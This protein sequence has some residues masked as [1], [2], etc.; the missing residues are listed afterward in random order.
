MYSLVTAELSKVKSYM[1]PC[2]DPLGRPIAMDRTITVRLPKELGQAFEALSARLK[3]LPKSV[4]VRVLLSGP[5]SRPL[6]EQVDLVLD[7]IRDGQKFG[8]RK[9]R[10]P[11]NS[12]KRIGTRGM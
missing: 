4:I 5:L 6:E 7:A 3:P 2:S 11:R 10:V 12:S 1:F 8:E 9:D